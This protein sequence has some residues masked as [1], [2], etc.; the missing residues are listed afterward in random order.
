MV[1]RHMRRIGI[2]HGACHALRHAC[3]THMLEAGA[4][5]RF[6]QVLLGHADLNTTQI[7]THVAIGKLAAVH[8]ATHPG[9]RLDA[10]LAVQ[11]RTAADV[12]DSDAQAL[13][14]A[15]AEDDDDADDACLDRP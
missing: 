11:A 10:G 1:V 2:E 3:A 8:A 13:L 4:D 12:Q 6:I 9:A 5:L 14:Q 7:Y 15:L